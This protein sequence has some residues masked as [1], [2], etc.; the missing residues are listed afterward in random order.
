MDA[1]RA[2]W[3][4]SPMM[5]KTNTVPRH[6]S[7]KNSFRGCR[8]ALRRTEL[9]RGGARWRPWLDSCIRITMSTLPQRMNENSLSPSPLS[10]GAPPYPRTEASD[11]D[12][13]AFFRN[14]RIDFT[15]CPQGARLGK[16]Q[17]KYA[18]TTGD[19]KDSN[20]SKS[21]DYW[22]TGSAREMEGRAHVGGVHPSNIFGKPLLDIR[23]Q[24]DTLR[25]L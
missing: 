23:M 9:P 17:E 5:W 10:S 22:M 6:L 19:R 8:R 2:R 18:L 13:R 20:S 15:K 25:K 24:Y 11:D 14:Q 16:F 3:P 21:L 7:R 12:A 1:F 4:S